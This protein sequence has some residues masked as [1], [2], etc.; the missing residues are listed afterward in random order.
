MAGFLS[1]LYGLRVDQPTQFRRLTRIRRRIYAT[2][3]PL[4]AEIVRSPEPTPFAE[5]DHGAFTR[6]L[7]GTAWGK[8]FDCAWLR[9]TGEVPAD[10]ENVYVMLGIR[11]EG[12]VVD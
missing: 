5:L 6:I 11:G 4:H 2:I 10:A 3:A 1:F 9:L 12:L 7:P 8:I